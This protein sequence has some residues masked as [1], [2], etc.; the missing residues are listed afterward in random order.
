MI[1]G[2]IQHNIIHHRNE[3]GLKTMCKE[4]NISYIEC[5]TI[6]EINNIDNEKANLVIT[7][8]VNLSLYSFNKR[9]IIYG[10][11]FVPDRHNPNLLLENIYNVLSEWNK[12]RHQ[13]LCPNNKFVCMPFPVDINTFKPL[14]YEF[15]ER[16]YTFLYIKNRNPNI[17]NFVKNKY[18]FDYIFSYGSYQEQDMLSKV[19][20]CKFG[21]WV[22]SHE[23]QGFALEQTLSCNVPLIVYNVKTLYDEWG[24]SY[25]Y[26]DWLSPNQSYATS[27]PYWDDNC[28]KIVYNN[29][30]LDIEYNKMQ[31]EWMNYKPR[32]YIVKELSSRVCFNK[33]NSILNENLP[34]LVC[35]TSV[36][37]TI[38]K[39]LSY[40]NVRSIYSV[41]E[42]IEQTKKSIES[43]RKYLPFATIVLIEGSKIDKEICEKFDVD[44][45]HFVNDED[46]NGPYK[47]AG[48]CKLLLSYLESDHHKSLNYDHFFKLS[49]RYILNENFNKDEFVKTD[50]NT[51]V[52][53]KT[54]ENQI[55][56]ILFKVGKNNINNF[57]DDLN[58]AYTRCLN[59]ESIENCILLNTNNSLYIKNLNK[60][61]VSGNIAIDG[62]KIDI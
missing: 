54:H 5:K 8:D 15:E 4:L 47:G 22:G 38:N 26:Q 31:T 32:E 37:K 50:R 41:E 7:Q 60:L 9:Y 24:Q 16:K 6:E 52:V 56:T 28:G 45:I 25:V 21:V 1:T 53:Y 42:R 19:Q 29:E 12:K 17:V 30:E 35:I 33:W 20:N 46:I 27:I 14:N 59:G 10:P 34:V 13:I 57:K 3:H 43:V 48:E 58:Q 39:P 2:I 62:Y 23:S 55:S 11:H 18:H 44:Y 49:G 51:N 36:I 61:G 40:S